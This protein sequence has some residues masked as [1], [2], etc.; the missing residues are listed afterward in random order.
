MLRAQDAVQKPLC[1]VQVRRSWCAIEEA[2]S[3]DEKLGRDPNETG[4]VLVEFCPH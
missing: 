1:I 4:V 3:I 2:A